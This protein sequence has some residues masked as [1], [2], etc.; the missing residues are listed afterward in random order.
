MS[1]S[2]KVRTTGRSL[3]VTIPGD[4]VALYDIKDGEEAIFEPLGERRFSMKILKAAIPPPP[5]ER[6]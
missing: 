3:V 5:P 4:L 1:L 6:K 2:R